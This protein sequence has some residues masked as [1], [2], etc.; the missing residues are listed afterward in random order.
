MFPTHCPL[1]TT[2]AVL[3]ERILFLHFVSAHQVDYLAIDGT[4]ILYAY[5]ELDI[6][7]CRLEV[8]ERIQI[9]ISCI[10]KKAFL[11]LILGYLFFV[12]ISFVG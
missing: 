6:A 1:R 7:L 5:I 8:H 9:V 2:T 3:L 4:V 10:P 12:L 11:I